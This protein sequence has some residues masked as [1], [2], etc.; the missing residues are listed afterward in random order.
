MLYVY[1]SCDEWKMYDSMRFKGVFDEYGLKDMLRQ[2]LREKEIEGI[3]EDDIVAFD[4]QSIKNNIKYGF[5]EPAVVNE[6]F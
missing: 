3:D 5:I 6:R 1:F 2:D 4:I